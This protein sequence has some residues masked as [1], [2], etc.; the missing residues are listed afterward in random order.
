MKSISYTQEMGDT[1]NISAWEGPT[2]SRSVSVVV[3]VV[4]IIV[5]FDEPG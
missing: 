4:V 2:G 5:V 1:E 3:I